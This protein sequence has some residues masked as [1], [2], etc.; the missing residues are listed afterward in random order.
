M[1]FFRAAEALAQTQLTIRP[2]YRP[3]HTPSNEELA[4]LKRL[5]AAVET[6]DLRCAIACHDAGIT[7]IFLSCAG[8]TEESM[9]AVFGKCHFVLHNRDE[10]KMLDRA[11]LPLLRDGY[12]ENVTIELISATGNDTDFTA[13]NIPQFARWL[14]LSETAAVR[15]V[16]LDLSAAENR[17][18]AARAAFSLV[19]KLRSDLPCILHCFCLR[20]LLSA[21]VQGDTELMQTLRMLASL[22]DTSLYADFLIG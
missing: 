14:R 6:D 10:L 3:E 2:M 21:A 8:Q 15:G 7:D 22:N 20:G 18:E 5:R 1:D 19:K 13:D 9:A 11:V 16:I 12:L 17:A 4:Q